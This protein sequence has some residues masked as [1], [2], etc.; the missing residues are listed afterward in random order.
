MRHDGL[1]RRDVM[2]KWLKALLYLVGAAILT[3]LIPFSNWFRMLDTM[4]HE[5]GHAIATLLTSGKVNRI[6]LY[7]NHSGVTY[8]SLL[9][10]GWS[11]FIVSIAGYTSASLFAIALFFSYSKWKHTAGLIT[12]TTI[13]LLSALLF[14]RNSYGLI[15]LFIF[16]LINVLFLLID[17]RLRSFYYLL[18]AFLC[19]EESVTAPLTLFILAITSPDQ[20]G[21]ATNLANLTGVPAVFWA[22]FFV[23]FSLLCARFALGLYWNRRE[24]KLG[25]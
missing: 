19:L 7:P 16:I 14:V 9:A 3:R 25:A 13:A 6:E 17:D 5:F 2:N 1:E 23:A 21:D 15:W 18:L 10:V 11:R 22:L 24:A 8:S 20:A 4:I 12:I